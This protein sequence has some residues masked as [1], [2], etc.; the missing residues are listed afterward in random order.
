MMVGD[1]NH[2]GLD[3]FSSRD[4]WSIRVACLLRSAGGLLGFKN[5]DQ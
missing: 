2:L 1:G 3:G 5:K 4:P